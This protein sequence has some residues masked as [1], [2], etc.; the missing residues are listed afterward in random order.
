M[1]DTTKDCVLAAALIALGAGALVVLA[2]TRSG[3]ANVADVV[4]FATL[5]RLYAGLL[6]GLGAL[7]GANALLKA[8]RQRA[9]G[10]AAARSRSSLADPKV[11]LRTVGALA[12]LV[13]YVIGLERFDFLAVTAAFLAAMFLLYGRGPLWRVL[14]IAAVGAAALDVL[15]VRI[16]D[17]PLH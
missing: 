11:L 16:I 1:P 5:P 17:L 10:A 12:L 6:I 13:L 4:G 7:L 15:F 14:L 3:G 2:H 9:A 8:L